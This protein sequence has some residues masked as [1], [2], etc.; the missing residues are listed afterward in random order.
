MSAPLADKLELWSFHSDFAIFSDGSLGCGFSLSPLDVECWDEARIDGLGAGLTSFVNGWPTGLDLQFSVSIGGGNRATVDRH[1]QLVSSPDSTVG[2]LQTLRESRLVALDD[3]GLLPRHSYRLFIRKPFSGSARIKR[4]LFQTGPRTRYLVEDQLAREIAAT[5]R[6]RDE[7]GRELEALGVSVSFLSQRDVAD[8]IYRQW[9]PNRPVALADYDPDDA[10]GGLLFTDAAISEQGFSLAATHFRVLSLK[11]LPDQTFSA[12]AKALGGLPFDSTLYLSIHV[13]DQQKE[14]DALQ[15]QRR[16]AFAM[17]RG[18]QTGAPDIDSETKFQDLEDLVSQMIAAGERIFHVSMNVVLRGKSEEELSD[19]AGQALAR[20]RELGGAEGMEETLAAFDIFCELSIPHARSRERARR[21]KTSNLIDFLPLYGPWTGHEEP[22]ILLRS[23][24]GDLIGIDPFAKELSNYNQMITGGS[25]S[26]KS[27][28]TNLCLL[29]MLKEN[30]RVF[31]VDIGGSYKKL[32]DNLTGQYIP[33]HL[34]S[35]LSLNPFDLAPG[36][37]IPSSHKIKF[38]VG[39][40]E[41]MT[42]EDAA[43]HLGKL[44]RAE[45]EATIQRVYLS[46]PA[47]SLSALRATLLEHPDA[48]I[49][50]FGK[51]LAPC[52][53]D[54]PY[55][56]IVDR[57]TSIE[58]TREVV[59]FDLKGLEV[60][61]DLQAACLYL[62]TDFV[63]REV[64]RERGRMKFL[65][66]DECWKLLE[67][68]SGAAF[69]AEVFRTFRKY[70]ASAIA[71]SQNVDD[72][73]KSRVASAILPNTAIKWVLS[74]RGADTVRLKEVLQLNDN[75][76]EWIGSLHQE[77][78][79]YSQAFLIAGEN[80]AVVTIEPTPLEYWIATTDPRDLAKFEEE[81]RRNSGQSTLEILE[82]LADVYPR[83]IAAEGNP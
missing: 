54:T 32:C 81:A 26:G 14:L 7:L 51:I 40:V 77:R 64:Q 57:P 10:R 5:E 6:L 13:P 78:G 74:Q 67:S 25:G 73:A 75:E 50:R 83:G 11:I 42:K 46:S 80:H 1:R 47:P 34:N 53:G 4:R 71:I 3:A 43:E 18:K 30:P 35:A 79:L 69:I 76:L 16:L 41:M 19:R 48:E 37:S 68:P 55:G 60:H 31:V 12:M 17:A 56:R 65:V 9:N 62:I 38:L 23:V 72:F 2:K 59:C 39:L 61:P 22:R 70:F 82:R 45:L 66:L 21:M 28:M 49:R 33:F 29:Q 52:C 44:E 63:W 20:I 58:L 8:L 27:F 15:T 36:E 24:E